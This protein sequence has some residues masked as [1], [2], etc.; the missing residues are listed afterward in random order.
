MKI[1]KRILLIHWYFFTYEM[2]EL[3]KINFL[4]GKNAS[5]KSTIIDALQL[6]FLVDT[7]GSYFNKAANGKGDRTLA[8]YLKG[9]WGEDNESGYKSVRGGKQFSSYIC[10]EFYDDVNQTNMTAGCCFDYFS[11]NDYQHTFF[12]FD[13]KIPD[14]RF[15]V[16]G[17]P[18]KRK[19]LK[20]FLKEEYG[21]KKSY[22][23]ETNRDFRDE[24]YAKL[25]GL[26]AR[27]GSLLKKAVPFNPISDIQKFI[28]EFVCEE[29][30]NVDISPMQESIRSYKNLEKERIK[31]ETKVQHLQEINKNFDEYRK[32]EENKNVYSYLIDRASFEIKKSNLNKALDSVKRLTEELNSLEKDT[33]KCS[34]E[35][36]VLNDEYTTKAVDLKN[37]SVTQTKER[38]ER[39]RAEKEAIVKKIIQ[40]FEHYKNVIRSSLIEWKRK[41]E[42]YVQFS[43]SVDT[44]FVDKILGEKISLF[45][46]KVAYF[47][48]IC[49]DF[50]EKK[51]FVQ[52]TRED[53]TRL[54]HTSEEIGS[55]LTLYKEDTAEELKKTTEKRRELEKEYELLSKGKIKFPDKVV[56]MQTL[57]QETIKVNHNIYS[58]VKILAEEI[59]IKDDRWRNVIE[60]YLNTQKHYLLV[61]PQYY[62]ES[63]VEY[64][65]IKKENKM[66]GIG[67]INIKDLE[68]KSYRHDKNSLAEEIQTD[69]QDA[70]LYID[71]VLGR[72][73]KCEDVT[74]LEKFPVSVTDTGMLYKGF[75]ARKMDPELWRNPTI[76][77]KAVAQKLVIVRDEIKTISMKEDV[78]SK[79]KSLLLQMDHLTKYSMSEIEQ[80]LLSIE[81]L[82]GIELLKNAIKKIEREIDGLDLSHIFELK[83][84]IDELKTKIRQKEKEMEAIL[85]KIGSKK[86][87][88]EA[89][90]RSIP[91]IKEDIDVAQKQLKAHFHDEWVEE[92]GNLRYLREYEINQKT[93]EEIAQNFKSPLGM[94]QKN[95]DDFWTKT[96]DCRRNFVTEYKLG[97]D[98]ED[99]QSNEIYENLYL[100]LSA[101]KLPEYKE[102]IE[103]AR[104]KTFEQFQEDFLS[105]LQANIQNTQLQIKNLNDALKNNPFGGDTYQFR[106]VPKDDYKRYYE[107]ITSDMLL[108]GYNILS[109]Q[110]NEKYK[111]EIQELFSL[112]TSEDGSP[113]EDYDRRVNEF[114]NYRTYLDFDLEVKDKS[115]DVQKLS[116]T[117]LKKSGG[118]TQ[119]PFYIAVLAS[120][121]Q[122]YRIGR[123]K[124]D[125]T[126]RII[127]FDEAFSKMDGDRIMQSIELLR[128]FGFQV[129]LSAPP[130]K[131]GDL[132]TLVDKNLCVLRDEH[133]SFVKTF[134]PQQ[135]GEIY[136]TE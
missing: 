17:E 3:G 106:I 55:S 29:Q 117:I 10:I 60:G 28:T 135:I 23:T 47:Q 83:K 14:N 35:K 7:S 131:I 128:K 80:T 74:H 105:R 20:K 99:K 33:K 30:G 118:E 129:I 40:D 65:K 113:Q 53:L 110:F 86:N 94:V 72:V 93:N 49:R 85:Q 26:P 34:D 44:S 111:D 4:T 68:R 134:T 59:E 124:N 5:G 37:D 8:G 125:N 77:S 91:A 66:F 63:L 9:E 115:G 2:I 130:D 122:I 100:E 64:N 103:N 119:T 79:I 67:L 43:K 126:A 127:L 52:S 71:Y 27:F 112:L 89:W 41:S 76:G 78:L 11:E 38:L 42:G 97:F 16:N 21:R 75:V 19:T 31:L 57:L 54:L 81:K 87:E 109:A 88:K 61:D 15:Q 84:S 108:S 101:I 36:N 22:Y 39:E 133:V 98:I 70:R 82:N 123:G 104:K 102:K 32:C 136:E 1:M 121:A 116:R 120:F 92:V 18:M 62:T 114:T 6:L 96:R 90:E 24:F 58:P 50:L 13:D 73:I 107:M 95:S 48:E 51:D 45:S 56:Q 69:N 12:L 132:A 25:G 46:E